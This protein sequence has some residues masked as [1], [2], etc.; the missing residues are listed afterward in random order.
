MSADL[1]IRKVVIPGRAEPYY[2]R[3]FDLPGYQ[4][5]LAAIVEAAQPA[6]DEKPQRLS[7]G[8]SALPVTGSSPEPTPTLDLRELALALT[9]CAVDGTLL[10]PTGRIAGF[11]D[12]LNG[13]VVAA[14]YLATAE[15]NC[16]LPVSQGEITGAR[17]FTTA[18]SP[19]STGRGWR[20]IFASLMSK[21]S[22]AD[23]GSKD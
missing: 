18:T 16:L 21:R 9:W 8:K 20:G 3:E 6:A 10:Y 22:N 11:N 4:R 14:L 23:S 15:L 13:R 17:N 19:S 5:W 7:P 1:V 2:V 12:K